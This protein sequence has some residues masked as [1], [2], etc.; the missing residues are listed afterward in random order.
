MSWSLPPP[1][2]KVASSPIYPSLRQAPG[3]SLGCAAS[4]EGHG[5]EQGERGAQRP[6]PSPSTA[7][8][9]MATPMCPGDPGSPPATPVPCAQN[10]WTESKGPSAAFPAGSRGAAGVAAVEQAKHPPNPC[11]WDRCSGREQQGWPG[12]PVQQHFCDYYRPGKDQPTSSAPSELS[13][14]KSC[15]KWWSLVRSGVLQLHNRI[16]CGGEPK[17]HPCGSTEVNGRGW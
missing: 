8:H 6:Q 2:C 1:G 12:I 14:D 13:G 7:C 5:A 16:P 9:P 4:A 15:S 17:S 3:E 10:C 11:S